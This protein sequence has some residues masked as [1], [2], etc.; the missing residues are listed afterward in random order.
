MAG[1]VAAGAAEIV[2]PRRVIVRFRA[3]PELHR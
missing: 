3:A 2:R 1:S